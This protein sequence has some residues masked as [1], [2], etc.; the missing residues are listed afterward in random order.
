MGSFTSTSEVWLNAWQQAGRKPDNTA[1]SASSA[2]SRHIDNTLS[3]AHCLH[4]QG[5][6]RK[7]FSQVMHAPSTHAASEHIEPQEDRAEEEEEER[8]TTVGNVRDLQA[9]IGGVS[10]PIDDRL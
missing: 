8:P 7:S 3:R 9:D 6:T 2:R 5:I 4:I 1:F 10:D